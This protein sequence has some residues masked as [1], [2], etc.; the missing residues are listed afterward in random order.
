MIVQTGIGPLH[1][2]GLNPSQHR[3][4]DDVQ[5]RGRGQ[6]DNA[7]QP[8]GT[9]EVYDGI[10]PRTDVEGWA[11]GCRLLHTAPYLFQGLRSK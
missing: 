8:A 7:L 4:H 6:R 1:P 9:G 5:Q 11:T 3:S 2:A 10:P